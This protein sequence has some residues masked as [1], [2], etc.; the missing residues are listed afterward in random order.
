M[1]L[2]SEIFYSTEINGLFSDRN[3]IAEMLRFEAALAQAQ[4]KNGIVSE[5][6]AAIIVDC[7]DAYLIDIEK[8][9][10]EI[11]LGG[12]AAIPLVKQLTRI[13]K[14]NDVEA[15]KMVHLGATSQD[16]VDT[17]MVLQIKAFLAW[18]EPKLSQLRLLLVA[19][20]QKHRSTL[21]I[22]RTLLQQARPITFGLKT[23]GWLQ[24][25][26]QCQELISETKKRVLCLT[27]GGA[28]GSGNDSI[29][30]KVQLTMAEL[31]EIAPPSGVGGLSEWASVLGILVGSLG[32]IAKDV[33]LLMQTEV[34]EVLEGAGEGKGGSSTMPH[35]R[36]PVTCAALLANA[37]RTPHLVATVLSAMPQEHER[38]AGLWHSE[39][40][41]L[42]ELM[43]LTAGSVERA[44]EL[45]GGLEV[46]EKRMLA[47][48]EVT[49]GL[50]YAENV[51]LAL[52]PKMGKMQA[53]ELVEKACKMAIH[54]QKHLKEV[55]ID[56]QLDLPDLEELFKPENSIG[57]SLELIDEVLRQV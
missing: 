34:G 13:V 37:T 10:S 21:M 1:S 39:W 15:S 24:R 17:A 41:V 25:V 23:A 11:K 40:E 5:T 50:I 35:K 29:N 32:K 19:L 8:L 27:L 2:Y 28:V 6:S 56:F 30:R 57:L 43:T 47:N 18:L 54:Q 46:D 45:V 51:S 49:K 14:N 42:V 52:A 26:K 44:I 36:N 38:S 16:V 3:T 33:S 20:T 53:H 55:L 12:N 7:C 22:G 48:L 9:K 4:A 31:L